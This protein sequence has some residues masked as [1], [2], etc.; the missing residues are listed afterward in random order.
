MSAPI[1][2][3]RVFDKLDVLVQELTRPVRYE[4]GAIE[5]FL[6]DPARIL[7]VQNKTRIVF[8]LGGGGSIPDQVSFP[9]IFFNADFMSELEHGASVIIIAIDDTFEHEHIRDSFKGKVAKMFHD[10]RPAGNSVYVSRIIPDLYSYIH[11]CFLPIRIPSCVDRKELAKTT[12]LL[13]R[14]GASLKHYANNPPCEM[15]FEHKVENTHWINVF[16]TLVQKLKD[17]KVYVQNDAWWDTS[18]PFDIH[19][20]HLHPSVGRI[21]KFGIN[22]EQ[23]GIIPFI[24]GKYFPSAN[25]FIVRIRDDAPE[26]HPF[27][28]EDAIIKYFRTDF[29]RPENA[30]YLGLTG[31]SRRRARRTRRRQRSSR[32]T[33]GRRT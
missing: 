14:P 24:F 22:F 9:N 2:K 30:A 4:P 1:F 25:L 17:F 28:G 26:I 21:Y 11:I 3:D 33:R 27:F 29:T 13:Q 8:S 20:E 19:H 7:E 15:D 16:T 12:Y 6:H 32:R 5:G 31:G 18:V 10:E 23:L